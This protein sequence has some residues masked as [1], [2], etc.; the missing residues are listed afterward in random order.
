MPD[1]YYLVSKWWKQILSIVVLSLVVVGLPLYLQ[2]VKYS[3]TTTALPASSYAADKARIFNNSIQSLYPA[4]GTPDDLDMIIG[5]AQLDTAYIAIAEQ[6]DLAAHY[7]VS[8]KGE[9]AK[10]KAAY[11]L[12][13]NTRVIKND[14]SELK[15]KVWDRDKTFPS[16][17]ANIIME[18]LKAMHEDMRNESNHTVL[19][20][21][22][23]TRAKI[24]VQVDSTSNF[25]KNTGSEGQ[26]IRKQGLIGQLQQY[27]KLIGEYQLIVDNKPP[28]LIVVEK[29]RVSDWPDKP[30][31]LRVL[32][33]TF[34]LSLI[35]GLL[36][37]LL[38]E[39]VKR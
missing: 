6:F 36:A 2:P 18:K 31:Y 33:A 37:V 38:I 1:L 15:V 23:A 20:S 5:T 29:A 39:K 27:E 8:E 13:A 14:Y 26:L 4:M 12:K 35:F 34:V 28:V 11:S 9:A 3:A 16:Q 10:L 19:K 22:E 32:M 25:I 21:L 7:K 17:F 24:Q 30:K